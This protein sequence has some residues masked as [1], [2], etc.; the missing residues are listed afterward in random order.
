[1]PSASRQDWAGR[2]VPEST[3]NWVEVSSVTMRSGRS[4]DG[5]PDS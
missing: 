2:T 3:M 1:M 5:M 4:L